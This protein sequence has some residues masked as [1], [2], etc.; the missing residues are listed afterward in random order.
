ML[1]GA[2]NTES[3]VELGSHDLA[4]LTDLRFAGHQV[5]IHHGSGG[6]QSCPHLFGKLIKSGKSFFVE[7][8]AASGNDALGSEQ[9]RTIACRFF[10]THKF[11]SAGRR[12][13]RKLL[14]GSISAFGWNRLK[15]GS[16]DTCY[17]RCCGGFDGSQN[18]ARV[19]VALE[20]IGGD[21]ACNFSES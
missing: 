15:R 8:T 11:K 7:E 10:H 6:T 14:N 19:D 2:G 4:G 13:H 17:N 9:I 16:T 5:H 12:R 20:R 3:H 18:A 21:H 1:N